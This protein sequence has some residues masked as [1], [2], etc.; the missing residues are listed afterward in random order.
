MFTYPICSFLDVLMN[1]FDKTCFSLNIKYVVEVESSY[2][3]EEGK[4]H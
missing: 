3:K 1:Y 4:I 2:K